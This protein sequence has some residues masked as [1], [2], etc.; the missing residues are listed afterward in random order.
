MEEFDPTK[1]KRGSFTELTITDLAFGGKGIAKVPTEKGDFV[2]FVPNSIPGQ[3]VK[4]QLTKKRKA[5]AECRLVEVLKN[6]D[7][8]VETPYQAIAGAPYATL[9]IEDQQAYKKRTTLEVLRRIGNVQNVEDLLDEFI[10]SPRTWHYRNKMEYSFG[11]IRYDFDQKKDVDDFGLGSKR[12]GTW[13]MVENLEKDS[14]LFDQALEEQFP[15]IR[16][17]C[18]NSGLPPWHAPKKEGF[19]RFLIVRKSFAADQLLVTLVTSSN[20]IKSFDFEAFVDLLK[21][22]LGDRLAG[23]IHTINDSVA[24]RAMVEEGESRLLYGQPM[25]VESINGLNFEISM[26]SFFQPNPGSAE[27]LYNKVIEY[28]LEN[29]VED[30]DKNVV[31]DLFCGTGTIGQI[32]ASRNDQGYH[33]VGVDIIPEAIENAKANAT[34]NGIEGVEFYAADVKHFLR[35]YPNYQGKIKTIVM[36]PPRAGIAPKTLKLVIDLQAPRIVYVSCNPATQAR[37]IDTLT[38]AGYAMKKVSLV[39][40]FPHT[41]HIESVAVFEKMTVEA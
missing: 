9:S 17:F 41:S 38:Q 11:A 18:I 5:F 35:E 3:R 31:M 39:D 21:S 4:V 27:L 36:D 16:N 22:L 24:D 34:R 23:V 7:M 10:A 25:I 15:A 37:D 26:E 6:S 30:S 33:I 20:G 13:W 12:R 40:Q 32:L 28:A 14:G 2:F 8:E 19:F 29:E 1:A